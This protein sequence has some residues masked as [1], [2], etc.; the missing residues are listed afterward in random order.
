MV[1]ADFNGDRRL[2]LYVANDGA[3]N[4]LWLQLEGGTFRDEAL[5]A[6]VAVNRA[7]QPEASMGIDAGDVDGDGDPDLVLAHLMGETNTLYLNDGQGLFTDRS[8]ETGLAAPSFSFT[9]FGAGWIDYDND[10]LLDLLTL[11]GAVKILE[12]A[13]RQ[14]DPYP[15]AQP[16]QLFRN[17]GGGRFEEVTAQAGDA[18]AVAEVSRGAAFGDVDNDGDLD[19]LVT[20]SNGRARLLENEV[21]SRRPWLGLRLVAGRR[22]QLGAVATVTRKEAPALVRRARTDGSYCSAHDPRVLIGLGAAAAIAAVR[23]D[24]PDGKSETWQKVPL[25]TYTTLRQGS[26]KPVP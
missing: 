16:N 14:G 13:A 1:S 3:V 20:N 5:L 2:D 17:L 12:E 9:S 8:A 4:Q 10:G 15:L 18:F 21:G 24:W 25:E 19:V 23:V 26:G 22:D 6:G 11:S 7:G